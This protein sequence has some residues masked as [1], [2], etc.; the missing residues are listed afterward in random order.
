[1]KRIL[2]PTDFS[3]C[4]RTAEN[5]AMALAK[6]AKAELHFIHAVYT[7]VEWEKLPVEKE[8]NYP[9]TKAIIGEARH[10]LSELG[11]RAE[12]MGV[13]ARSQLVYNRGREEI[14]N[15]VNSQDIDLVVMGSHGADGVKEILGSNAQMLVRHAPVPVL[16]VKKTDRP[17]DFQKIVF[18]S[19]FDV[20]FVPQYHTLRDFAKVIKAEVYLLWVNTPYEFRETAEAELKFEQFMT[21]ANERGVPFHIYNALNEERGI[22]QFAERHGADAIAVATR[23]RTDLVR[24]IAPS[25]TEG[26][27][28]HADLPVLSLK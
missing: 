12:K 26:L 17:L 11:K 21:A 23:G 19:T 9:E 24:L 6:K 8:K 20:D 25:I 4:A 28:N 22:T 10:K 7:P 27:V 18:A 5:S 13:A 3:E 2:V 14:L 15:Y 1:M 16:V